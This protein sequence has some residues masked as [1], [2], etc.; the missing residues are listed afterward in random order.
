MKSTGEV[1]EEEA[2]SLLD[3]DIDALKEYLY[4]TSAG[5]IKKIGA[6][7]NAELKEIL[8]MEEGEKQLEAF[9][10]YLGDNFCAPSRGT[11]ADV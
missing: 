4:Y 8:E 2:I 11:V 7:R 10:K 3:K 6:P 9:T 5:Y 1:S